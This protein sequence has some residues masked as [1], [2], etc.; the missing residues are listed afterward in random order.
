MK[1]I[2]FIDGQEGTTGLQIYERLDKRDDIELI[3]INENKRKDTTERKKLIN[4]ANLVF[5]CLPDDA[6]RES[7]TLIDNNETRVID[8]SVAHRTAPD[9]VYGFPEMSKKQRESIVNA[10]RTTN[11]GCH[12]TGA[13]ALLAPLTEA[14][15]LPRDY[16]IAITSLTGYTGGGKSK[17][18][19]YETSDR[20][21]RNDL[22]SPRAY[23]LGAEHK[24]IPE[25]TLYSGLAFKPSFIPVIADYPQGMQV[26]I[27]LHMPGKRREVY[28]IL[29]SHYA[30][31]ENID[32][33]DEAPAFSASNVNADTDRL[34]LVVS[35][36]G[37]NVVLTSLFDNLGKGACGAAIQNMNLMLGF[38]EYEGLVLNR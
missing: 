22:N 38:G 17:I 26:I 7:V 34:T 31:C 9:W 16:P 33:F 11:P 32:V 25:I 36:S 35:G 10:K 20:E 29:A 12:S 3:L 4:E 13:I 15:F 30:G 14:G 8:A 37:D 1:P 2:V 5:L 21:E 24:H 28:D 23:S 27:P 18:A 6:A 19:E